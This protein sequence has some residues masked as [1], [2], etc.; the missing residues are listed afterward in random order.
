MVSNAAVDF[1]RPCLQ[2][3]TARQRRISERGSA[4]SRAGQST[5]RLSRPSTNR[6]S[7]TR[8]DTPP[9][10]WGF[11]CGRRCQ[12][13]WLRVWRAWGTAEPERLDAW[14]FR[15]V[16]NTCVD[17]FRVMRRLDGAKAGVPALVDPLSVEELVAERAS[18]PRRTRY[19]APITAVA[20]DALAARSHRIEL[21][22]D[23]PGAGH[24][25][26]NPYVPSHSARRKAARWLRAGGL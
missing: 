11:G 19:I 2:G 3:N 8:C 10:S 23:R 7:R 20:G 25:S 22:R 24:S 14:V 1:P 9:P 15:I 6:R 26:R 17:R 18:E 21:P 12:D 4:S 5:D 16:R 13:T